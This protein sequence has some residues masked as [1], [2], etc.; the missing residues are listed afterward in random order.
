MIRTV[1]QYVD[2][3]IFGGSEQVLLQLLAGL[4]RGRW[5][6]VLLHHPEP[7]LARTAKGQRGYGRELTEVHVGPEVHVQRTTAAL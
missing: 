4:D 6:P 2:S 3:S 1:V 7:G 5:R